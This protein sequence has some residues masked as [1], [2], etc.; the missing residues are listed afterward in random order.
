MFRAAAFALLLFAQNLAAADQ[1][2]VTFDDL[3][4]NGELAPGTT[5]D[6][7]VAAV[8]PILKK[9]GLPPVYGFVNAKKLE[10]SD[11]GAAALRQWVAGGQRV[12]N[13]TYAHIDLHKST[14]DA[15]LA[16]LSQDEPVL[17]LL[18]PAGN[19]R[20]LRYPYLREGDTVEKRREVRAALKD[21]RYRIAQ[22]T[23]DYEDYLWNT[24][25]A[26]CVAAHDTK[27]IAWLRSSYLDVARAYLRGNRQMADLVFGHPIKHVLLLHLGA[28]S[29]T[30]LPDLFDLMKK[31]GFSFVTLEEA[32]SDPAYDT[33]PDAGSKYGGTLLEQWMDV[34][35]I[36]YPDLP[37][38]PYKQL[39]AICR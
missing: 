27:S 26:R 16:E 3:P 20:W 25:Y 39:D 11:D 31:E 1:V 28:F 5:R 12:G 18:D 34:R 13:H 15:F 14:P 24:A 22:V 2:A 35:H 6:G 32:Q 4:L 17:E 10:G 8:L 19:W 21:R 33:D 29:S 9:Y 23:L 38:K 30:I 7:I 37:K 36:A